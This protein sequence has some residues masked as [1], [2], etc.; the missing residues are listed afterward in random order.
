[1]SQAELYI[2]LRF[3]LRCFVAGASYA[4][5][6]PAVRLVS[7]AVGA[8][9]FGAC[10]TGRFC[11]NA[12]RLQAGNIWNKYKHMLTA[13]VSEGVTTAANKLKTVVSLRAT[14]VIHVLGQLA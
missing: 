4:V 9:L 11:H 1:M 2:F 12:H 14:K 10:R 5:S 13:V 7:S 3:F 6:S 8:R